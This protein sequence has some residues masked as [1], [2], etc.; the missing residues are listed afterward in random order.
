MGIRGVLLGHQRLPYAVVSNTFP[1][2]DRLV[3]VVELYDGHRYV[4]R[5]VQRLVLLLPKKH[6]ENQQNQDEPSCPLEDVQASN[7]EGI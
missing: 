1:G 3:R 2:P 5:A 4:K 6:E 7:P